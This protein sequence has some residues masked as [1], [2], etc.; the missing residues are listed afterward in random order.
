MIEHGRYPVVPCLRVQGHCRDTVGTLLGQ[1]CSCHC[2]AANTWSEC[3]PV[4]AW[5]HLFSA[6]GIMLPFLPLNLYLL[7][8][9]N[10]AQWIYASRSGRCFFFV[11]LPMSGEGV[12]WVLHLSFHQGLYPAGLGASCGEYHG[13]CAPFSFTSLVLNTPQCDSIIILIA[14]TRQVDRNTLGIVMTIGNPTT[15][16]LD[17]VF[18]FPC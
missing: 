16:W 11:F 18:V 1:G 10:L 3:S 13:D 12:S 9:P 6:T 4:K 8:P 2:Q 5:P 7:L 17:H 14:I 15:W